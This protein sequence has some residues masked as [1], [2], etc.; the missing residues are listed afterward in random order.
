L[1]FYDTYGVDEYWE[2]DPARGRLRVWE[3]REGSLVEV[4]AVDSW[5]STVCGC[6]L[7]V[8]GDEL[9]AFDPDGTR[10]P[11]LPER[12]L[13]R[14]KNRRLEHDAELARHDAELARHDAEL[15]RH[16]AEVLRHEAARAAARNAELEAELARLRGD[17]H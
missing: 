6:R 13:L 11:T 9:V 4:V 15:A 10:W 5:C 3:R 7:A 14:G 12:A 17:E 2:F 16:D 1:A 8:Q